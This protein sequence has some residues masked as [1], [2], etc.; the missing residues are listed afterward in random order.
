M[1]LLEGEAKAQQLLDAMSFNLVDVCTIT[2]SKQPTV[3]RLRVDG[4]E[5]LHVVRGIP[6]WKRA[7]LRMR[8]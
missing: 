8:R 1:F 4:M 5:Y 6:S 7:S 3:W 2:S